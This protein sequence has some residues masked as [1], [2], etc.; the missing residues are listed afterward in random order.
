[1][2]HIILSI[3][4]MSVVWYAWITFKKIGRLRA[5]DID[6]SE[7][8]RQQRQVSYVMR[9]AMCL[10]LLAILPFLFTFITK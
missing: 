6:L 8:E 4:T 3:I 9:I 7:Q 5:V 10:I 2:Q 1:M